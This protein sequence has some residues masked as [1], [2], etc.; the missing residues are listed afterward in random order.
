[1]ADEEIVTE[2]QP[3]EA[4]RDLSLDEAFSPVI[5]KMGTQAAGVVDIGEGAYTP[6]TQTAQDSEMLTSAQ[7]GLGSSPDVAGTSLQDTAIVSAPER[8]TPTQIENISRNLDNMPTDVQGATISMNA[9]AVVDPAAIVDERTKDELLHEG[10]L[11]EAKTQEL[12]L[13]ATTQFQLES[14]Y[15]SLEEGKPLPGWAAKNV[16]KVQDIMNAR[17]LGSSSVAA[18]AMVQAI[19]ES[20]LPIAVQDANKYAAIQLQNLN[21]EQQTALSNAATIASLDKQ[22]LDNRMK[23]A[24]MN[25]Q[26]FLQMDFKNADY[27]QQINTINYEAKKQ[28]LF[29]DSAAA[30]AALQINA[31]TQNDVDK[32]YD[33]MGLS[34]ETANANRQVA[35][36][37]FNVD[38]ANSIKKYNA[39]MNDERDKFNANMSVQIDQSNALW[40][41]TINTANTAEA[42]AANRTN[43]AAILG[44]SNASLNALWQQYRDEASFAFTATE[45][46]IARDQQLAL[47]ILQ[48][49]FAEEM[50]E[51][52]IDADEEKQLSVFLGSLLSDTFEAVSG[53]VAK[54]LIS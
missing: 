27:E 13:Q 46:D 30:N 9:N 15:E 37:Q 23:A 36:D 6:Q 44:I 39:K 33:Q 43:A 5:D 38:Q 10:T 11:A 4:A 49:Q 54:N 28:A 19:S 50:F 14:L 2:E 20:A 16:R 31:K 42:N 17:G 21:N 12:A 40:R 8:I 34:V 1:M 26:S 25:A 41:R 24:Q 51:A 45:N 32:F 47:T 52:Q 18:A 22:N 7:Y 35:N 53:A 29:T 48:N 3:Q